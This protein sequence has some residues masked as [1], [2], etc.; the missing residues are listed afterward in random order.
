MASPGLS[1]GALLQGER[2]RCRQV[3]LFAFI[4]V[5]CDTELCVALWPKK[6]K[7]AWRDTSALGGLTSAWGRSA[8]GATMGENAREAQQRCGTGNSN[9]GHVC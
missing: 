8:A 6:G 5:I 4:I 2:P 7:G 3:C 9:H 1:V